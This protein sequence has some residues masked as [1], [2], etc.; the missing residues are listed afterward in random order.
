MWH[1]SQ[2]IVDRKDGGIELE[3]EASGIEQIKA[4]V[5]GFGPHAQVLGPASLVDAVW[6]D[7]NALRTLYSLEVN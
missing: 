5:L 7:V 2:E 3:L 1:P 4:W 6:Q